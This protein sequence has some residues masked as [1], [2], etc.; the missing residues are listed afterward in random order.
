MG[1]E[2]ERVLPATRSTAFEVVCGS[3]P[4]RLPATTLRRP[5]QIFALFLVKLVART[6]M[7]SIRVI[8]R[9]IRICWAKAYYFSCCHDIIPCLRTVSWL[10]EPLKPSLIRQQ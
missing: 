4:C 10:S 6:K 9:E 1:V 7:P 2:N 8:I 3:V 5:P